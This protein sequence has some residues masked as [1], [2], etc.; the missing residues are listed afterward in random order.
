MIPQFYNSEPSSKLYA[1]LNA[2]AAENGN[3]ATSLVDLWDAIGIDDTT[4]DLLDNKWGKLL[5]ISRYTGEVDSAYRTRLKT[6][7]LKVS[8]GTADALKYA[9]GVIIGITDPEEIDAR[10]QVEDAWLYEATAEELPALD[11]DPGN[12]VCR[13]DIDGAPYINYGMDMNVM[14][15][16][17]INTIKAAGTHAIIFVYGTRLLTYADMSAKTYSELGAYRYYQLG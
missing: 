12:F 4:G 14:I 2:F 1:I 9:I 5:N 8:G 11:T 17:I 3:I 15:S 16:N 10:I 6:S 7:I 13:V